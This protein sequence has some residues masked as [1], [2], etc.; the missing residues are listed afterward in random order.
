MHRKNTAQ[1][2]FKQTITVVITALS[3]TTGRLTSSRL[4][5]L[6]GLYEPAATPVLGIPPSLCPE[7]KVSFPAPLPSPIASPPAYPPPR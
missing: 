4:G 5:P 3:E 7:G 6:L 1:T 2:T